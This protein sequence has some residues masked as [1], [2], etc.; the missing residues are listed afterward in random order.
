MII[1][2]GDMECPDLERSLA[3]L[4]MASFETAVLSSAPEGLK[5]LEKKYFDLIIFF[6]SG[7]FK[8]DIESLFLLKRAAR[9]APLIAV[10]ECEFGGEEV[11]AL[12]KVSDDYLLKGHFDDE[13]LSASVF[14]ALNK[15]AFAGSAIDEAALYSVEKLSRSGKTRRES[16]DDAVGGASDAVGGAF[17]EA[18][19][20]YV[21]HEMRN[22][23]NGIMG[24]IDMLA[25]TELDQTQKTYVAHLGEASRMLFSFLNATLDLSKVRDGKMTIEKIECDLRGLVVKICDI[26]GPA[27]ARKGLGISAVFDERLYFSV[28]A[29]PA[30][31]SQVLLNLVGN[32][33]KFTENGGVKISVLVEEQPLAF[34]AAGDHAAVKFIVSDTGPGIAPDAVEKI[35]EPYRQADASVYRNHGGSGLGLY[36]SDMLVKL[37][38]GERIFVESVKGR[39]SEFSFT[40]RLKKILKKENRLNDTGKIE[41]IKFENVGKAEKKMKILF[42]EDN[43]YNAELIMELLKKEGHSVTCVENGLKLLEAACGEKFGLIIMDINM[44]LMNGFEAAREIRRRGIQTPIVAISGSVEPGEAGEKLYAGAGIDKHLQKPVSIR[45]LSSLIGLYAA[46]QK[47]PSAVCIGA[48]SGYCGFGVDQTVFGCCAVMNNAGGN[49]AIANN[50]VN[51]FI[52]HYSRN[53]SDLKKAFENGNTEKIKFHAHKLKGSAFNGGAGSL[54]KLLNDIETDKTSGVIWRFEAVISDLERGY[55]KYKAEVAKFSGCCLKFRAA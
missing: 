28:L 51:S 38:G 4:K 20:A 10:A 2:N 19:A 30:R 1:S 33:L 21:A 18:G 53:F 43:F 39:G 48:P 26:E 47:S 7:D 52:K 36:I 22:P 15:S 31:I 29:D 9:P 45:T 40:L 12:E 42:A 34:N 14:Y 13:C 11:G 44:P 24:F 55:E 41:K 49:Q 6:F 46:E 23:L 16:G 32:S 50:F 37:M 25:M 27:A 17:V 35:F 3:A 8:R 5:T 54:A